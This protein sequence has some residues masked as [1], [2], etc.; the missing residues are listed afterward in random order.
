MG[1]GPWIFCHTHCRDG[2]IA[3][4]PVFSLLLEQLYRAG[5][6]AAVTWP[7]VIPCIQGPKVT[8]AHVLTSEA[9]L[10]VPTEPG[11]TAQRANSQGPQGKQTLPARICSE[12][13]IGV[14]IG[15]AIGDFV[16]PQIDTPSSPI[17]P[18][19]SGR[20]IYKNQ[21]TILCFNKWRLRCI[22]PHPDPKRQCYSHHSLD[23]KMNAATVFKS[24]GT[25]RAPIARWYY[26]A[27]SIQI[28][29]QLVIS[30]SRKLLIW[31]GKNPCFAVVETKVKSH[32]SPSQ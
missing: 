13:K 27:T 4:L 1:K 5:S 3:N 8:T 29:I 22:H 2:A 14:S 32:P 24:T 10:C 9:E 16:N 17:M 7:H 31:L 20:R 15:L 6:M 23:K 25:V 26:K 11:W 30:H 12:T 19:R 21:T 28:T 18:H